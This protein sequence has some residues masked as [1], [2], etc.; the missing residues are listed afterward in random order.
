MNA[1]AFQQYLATGQYVPTEDASPLSDL[2]RHDRRFH[3]NG[4]KEG[5]ACKYRESMAKGDNADDLMSAEKEEGEL[6]EEAD[7]LLKGE[8]VPSDGDRAKEIGAYIDKTT[9]FSGVVTDKEVIEN[10]I[11]KTHAINDDWKEW[12]KKDGNAEYPRFAKVASALSKH[13]E[14]NGLKFED[15]MPKILGNGD[16]SKSGHAYFR[17]ESDSGDWRE[18][19]EKMSKVFESARKEIGPG[20]AWWY[21]EDDGEYSVSF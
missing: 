16:D 18:A 2:E 20:F 5:D 9:D 10:Q 4:Y 12:W 21:D 19:G 17:L 14:G 13:L 1:K 7:L 8:M 6:K 3:P 15:D 11:E